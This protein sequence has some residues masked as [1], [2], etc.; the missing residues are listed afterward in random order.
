MCD[1]AH[2]TSDLQHDL[3]IVAY[4]DDDDLIID[5]ADPPPSS[6]ACFG[7]R[8]PLMDA[9]NVCAERAK[10][11][12]LM[13]AGDDLI[14]R[15]HGWDTHVR[16]AF[17]DTPDKILFAYANDGSPVHGD[18]FGTH[19][20]VSRRW[21]DALGYMVPPYFA[22]DFNDVWLNEIAGAVGR[23]RYLPGVLIEHMHP[24]WGKRP[25]DQTDYDRLERHSEQKPGRVYA[26]LAGERAR[27]V[28]KLRAVIEGR[29]AA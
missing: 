7:P 21:V 15:T 3:E 1:S 19:G 28:E 4:L 18:T 6:R 5:Y 23:K 10:G 16:K 11:D 25:Y 2:A 8:R 9:W 29:E 20:F 14:F 13:H 22:S 17:D 24:L 12:I 27:D 26:T